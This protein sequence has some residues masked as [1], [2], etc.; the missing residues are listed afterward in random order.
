MRVI[1]R[2]A[3]NQNV[4]QSFGTEKIHNLI[5]TLESNDLIARQ[6]IEISILFPKKLRENSARTANNL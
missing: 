3:V 5:L 4:L 2:W 6:I 1:S